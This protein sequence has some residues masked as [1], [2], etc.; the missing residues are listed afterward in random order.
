MASAIRRTYAAGPALFL[1]CTALTSF[2][3]PPYLPGKA[4]AYALVGTFSIR[5]V[6]PRLVWGIRPSDLIRTSTVRAVAGLEKLLPVLSVQ[7]TSSKAQFW[8]TFSA[9]QCSNFFPRSDALIVRGRRVCISIKPC[10]QNQAPANRFSL[11]DAGQQ[12]E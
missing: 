9:V 2:S 8:R 7:N 12:W 6:R 3:K 11:G 4:I 5:V 10:R 1:C